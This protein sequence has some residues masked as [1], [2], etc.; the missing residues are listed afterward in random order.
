MYKFFLFFFFLSKV[1][2]KDAV[3]HTTTIKYPPARTTTKNI[4]LSLPVGNNEKKR[5]E[6]GFA[7]ENGHIFRG[8]SICMYL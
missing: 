4:P 6:T 5:D 3:R 7:A 2:G 8:P 1:E